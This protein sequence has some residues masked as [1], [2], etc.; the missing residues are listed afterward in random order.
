MPTL[1]C[2]N[3]LALP[4]LICSSRPFSVAPYTRT[5]CCTSNAAAASSWLPPPPRPAHSCAHQ[6]SSFGKL[7]CWLL[8]MERGNRRQLA[9]AAAQ[10][11]AF[12]ARTDKGLWLV[13]SRQNEMSPRSTH[14]TGSTQMT[15]LSW[16]CIACTSGTAQLRAAG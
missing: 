14:M 5:G 2:W 15:I 4:R 16:A 10:P 3:V 13:Y 7:C 8:H 6:Q 1:Q 11:S 12:L 9:A